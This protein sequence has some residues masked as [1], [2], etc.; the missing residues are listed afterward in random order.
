MTYLPTGSF[1]DLARSIREVLF[2][3]PDDT[4]VFPGHMGET[5]IGHEK[6][7]NYMV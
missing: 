3:L 2:G 5:T 6:Q 7:F 4:L 1:S